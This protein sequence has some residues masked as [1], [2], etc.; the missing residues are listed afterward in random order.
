MIIN[1]LTHGDIQSQRTEFVR[2]A[3]G[4]QVLLVARPCVQ[5]VRCVAAY[6]GTK[7]IGNVM[8]DHAL[9]AQQVLLASADEMAVG[10]IVAVERDGFW[11][12]C[13]LGDV[14]LVSVEEVEAKLPL[15]L[16]DWTTSVAMLAPTVERLQRGELLQKLMWRYIGLGDTECIEEA[17]EALF[18]E[19][20]YDLS[21]E[22][23]SERKLL[24]QR[25]MQSDNERWQRA[26]GRLLEASQRMGG[27]HQMEEVG[28]W[29]R[30]ELPRS[31]EADLLVAETRHVARC[32]VV[33]EAEALPGN[34]YHLWQ[35]DS[36]LFARVLYGMRLQRGDVRRVL[37]CLIW[38]ERAPQED[39]N[40][41]AGTLGVEDIASY[42]K[43]CVGWD[44]AR[45]IVTML[46][47]LLR[48]EDTAELK[49]VDSIEE[50]FKARSGGN[51]FNAP[52]GQ[53]IQRADKIETK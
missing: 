10:R 21:G 49:V 16:N 34:L 8:L 46:N 31:L 18:A 25:L 47:K 5:D 43:E 17:A 22:M 53:V 42:C 20:R 45:P 40:D 19:M 12:R 24:T 9:L 6:V 36:A 37:S 48:S 35:T 38:L 28:L 1:G 51:T 26:A 2:E 15:G 27:D 50:E 7:R 44:D 13:D 32:R 23:Q 39:T 4:R 41:A 14:E 33:E 29:L 52:V 30:Q 11:L 3:V